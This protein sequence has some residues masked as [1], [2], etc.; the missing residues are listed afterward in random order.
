[1]WLLPTNGFSILQYI[2]VRASEH[3]GGYTKKCTVDRLLIALL[4]K[5]VS[6]RFCL[7]IQDVSKYQPSEMLLNRRVQF[8]MHLHRDLG[9]F[10]VGS[11]L[12]LF[13]HSVGHPFSYQYSY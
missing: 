9:F 11:Q 13:L 3:L 7:T 6:W 4:L 5:T 2:L 12:V 8:N 1:M 10:N